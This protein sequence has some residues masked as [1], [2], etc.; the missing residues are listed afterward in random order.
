MDSPFHPDD[1]KPEKGRERVHS[2]PIQP[3]LLGTFGGKLSKQSL[4]HLGRSAW[5]PPALP[6]ALSGCPS[7]NIWGDD[8]EGIWRKPC[9]TFFLQLSLDCF[10]WSKSKSYPLVFLAP[11]FLLPLF[12]NYS[13][14][15]FFP[16]SPILKVKDARLTTASGEREMERG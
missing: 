8:G 3:G 7:T 9:V 15:L 14:F 6:P 5:P 2:A 4:H 12:S 10:T 1:Q 11:H 16:F 13:I